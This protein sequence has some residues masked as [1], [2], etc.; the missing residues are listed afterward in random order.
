MDYTVLLI[1]IA[2]AI[3]LFRIGKSE[4]NKGSLF[5]VISLL[6]SVITFFGLNWGKLASIAVQFGFL[7]VLTGINI[8]KKP[9]SK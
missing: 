9:W 3:M 8:Y 2:F 4:H 7:A 1:I 5:A 6:L